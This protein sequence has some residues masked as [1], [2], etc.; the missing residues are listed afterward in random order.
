MNVTELDRQQI[1]VLV[2]VFAMVGSSVV[3]VLAYAF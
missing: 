3:Y 2:M 1:L